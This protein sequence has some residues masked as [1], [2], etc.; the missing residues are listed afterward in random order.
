MCRLHKIQITPLE[1]G[2]PETGLELRDVVACI[3]FGLQP[4]QKTH[5][6]NVI[7]T[8]CRIDVETYEADAIPQV[9]LSQTLS[10]SCVLECHPFLDE[11]WCNS[12][13]EVSDQE[14]DDVRGLWRDEHLQQVGH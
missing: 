12:I 4:R 9:C 2:E 13:S 3:Q 11:G 5:L 1:L 7:S 14:G 6:V 10:L 8:R